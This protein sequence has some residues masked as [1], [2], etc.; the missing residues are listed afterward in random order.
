MMRKEYKLWFNVYKSLVQYQPSTNMRTAGMVFTLT[1]PD[2]HDRILTDPAYRLQ[3]LT[4]AE[5][6]ANVYQHAIN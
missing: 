4:E 6:K 5:N 2:Q 3:K 1:N